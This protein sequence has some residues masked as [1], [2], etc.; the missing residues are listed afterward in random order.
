MAGRVEEVVKL[1]G[2]LISSP[3]LE[4]D[5]VSFNTAVMACTRAGDWKLGK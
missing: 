5:V 1:L 3:A 4:A 2:K